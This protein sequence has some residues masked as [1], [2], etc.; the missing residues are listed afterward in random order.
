MFS[1]FQAVAFLAI[2][3]LSVW[4]WYHVCRAIWTGRA[5]VH[6]DIVRRRDRPVYYWLA[7]V[8]QAVFAALCMLG[9]A[10]GLVRWVSV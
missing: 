4:F 6:N 8:A 7:V 1:A 5:N 3:A 2:S 9:I 10:R